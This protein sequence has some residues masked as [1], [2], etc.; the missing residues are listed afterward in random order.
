M[1]PN[2]PLFQIMVFSQVINGALLPVILVCMLALISNRL[3]RTRF[4]GNPQP[5][6]E[7][8]SLNGVDYT[9]V[10]GIGQHIWKWSV[11]LDA[12]PP[13]TG[14]AW[15]RA[16][17]RDHFARHFSWPAIGR[18]AMAIYDDVVRHR[19]GEA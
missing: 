11:S 8:V 12:S 6:G 14:S 15:R 2:L 16:E 1:F 9:V 10:Q 5:L 13:T 3:W 4:A 19:R 7:A 17:V 18:R